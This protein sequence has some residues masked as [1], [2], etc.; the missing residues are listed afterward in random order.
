MEDNET[1]VEAYYGFYKLTTI[2]DAN[3]LPSLILITVSLKEHWDK[4]ENLM[5]VFCVFSDEVPIIS[6][7]SKEIIEVVWEKLYVML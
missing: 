6:F 2:F 5:C 4:E 7:E 1:Q 3:F